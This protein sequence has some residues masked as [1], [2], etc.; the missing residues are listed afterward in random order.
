MSSA[1][2]S[3]SNAR[4]AHWLAAAVAL[5][6]VVGCGGSGPALLSTG[7]I[8]CRRYVGGNSQIYVI[9]VDGSGG[10]YLTNDATW[11]AGPAW[12]PDGQKIAFAS[13]ASGTGQ[14]YVMNADGSDQINLSNDDSVWDEGP[15]WSPDGRRITFMRISHGSKEIYVMDAD[16]SNQVGL[17]R[18]P[19][20]D[21]YPSEASPQTDEHVGG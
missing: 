5:V 12:S 18:H 16:G 19:G 11:H 3:V 6:S 2:D 9:N 21:F 1:R 8:A 17:S 7:T 15:S 20:S 4:V 10:V 13:G 14:I